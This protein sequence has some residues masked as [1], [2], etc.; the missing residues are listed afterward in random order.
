MLVRCLKRLVFLW[1]HNQCIYFDNE[2]ETEEKPTV[3]TPE[4]K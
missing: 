3:L 1:S 2:E 4:K